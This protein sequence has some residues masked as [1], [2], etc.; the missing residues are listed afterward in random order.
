MEQEELR[1]IKRASQGD[2]EAFNTLMAAHERRMYAVALRKMG[3]REDAQDCLQ[4]AMLRVYRSIS[5]F[6]G[7]SAFSTWVYTITVNTCLDELRRRKNV[8]N[9]SM[10]SLM[11]DG[12]MPVDPGETPEEG[13]V[14]RQTRA[15][16]L[17]ALKDLPEDMR[18]AVELRDLQG[19]SYE[20]IAGILDINIGTV[21]SRISRG[22]GKLR[23]VIRKMPELF[24]LDSV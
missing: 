6:R 2:A 19:F 12:W 10:D 21:R 20:E 5:K 11:D 16:L 9:T 3:N 24:G 17:K 4:D 1:L 18:H 23:D 15:C 13:A 7:D 22:R 14:R 8:R